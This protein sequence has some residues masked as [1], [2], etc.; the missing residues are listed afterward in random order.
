MKINKA[1]TLRFALI[2]SAVVVVSFSAM[3]GLTA[4]RGDSSLK[5]SFGR[6]QS[7][8][9][10]IITGDGRPVPFRWDGSNRWVYGEDRD[11]LM[12]KPYTIRLRNNSSD[13]LK[14]VVAIDGLNVYFRERVE[15]RASGDIGSILQPNADRTI[16]GWQINEDE[17]QEFVFSPTDF[18]E[19][20]GISEDQIGRIEIHIYQEYKPRH[21]YRTAPG[22]E[23]QEK[24]QGESELGTAAGEVVDSEIRRVTF[25]TAT[26]EPAV[27]AFITYGRFE[28]GS[29]WGGGIRLGITGEAVDEGVMIKQVEV[30]SL[31][32]EAGLRR[33]D[34][35]TRVNNE[36]SPDLSDLR[37]ATR[38]KKRGEYV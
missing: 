15:G 16:K 30:D 5:I 29:R 24:A 12:G 18:A 14:V 3:I 9:A 19:A 35:I 34:I 31:A 26:E 32:D 4:P 21:D 20:Q 36:Q 37:N 10:Q 13:R 22:V 11:A 7:V 6:N 1:T 27:R 17:A 2:I 25:I 23:G 33:G 28:R 38:E 8:T